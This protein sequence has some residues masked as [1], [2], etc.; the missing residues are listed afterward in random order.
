MFSVQAQV[1]LVRGEHHRVYA[2]AHQGLVAAA[3]V[4][5]LGVVEPSLSRIA[6]MLPDIT[7][8]N[9][10][11]YICLLSTWCESGDSGRNNE[12]SRTRAAIK[13]EREVMRKEVKILD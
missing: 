2:P 7:V 10:L 3:L 5:T 8:L 9:P 6:C 13:N 1:S 12:Q 4:V 11:F